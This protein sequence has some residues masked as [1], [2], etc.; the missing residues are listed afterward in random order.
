MDRA[1]GQQRPGLQGQAVVSRS[2]SGDAGI[3]MLGDLPY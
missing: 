3:Q 2:S 1:D